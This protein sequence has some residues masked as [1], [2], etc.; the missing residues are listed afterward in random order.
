MN[1]VQHSRTVPV[2]PILRLTHLS[3]GYGKRTVLRDVTFEVGVGQ[4]W[5]FLGQNGGGKT[6][7][8]K[9]ILGLLPP[10]SGSLW[11]HPD[12]AKRDKTGFVP[13]RCDLNPSLPTTV[14]EF[15]LL[16]LVGV[17]VSRQEQQARLA[18]TLDKM[19]LTALAEHNYWSLSGGQ[20]Q[21]TLVARALVRRP[22]LLVL[23][24]P[25]NNLDLPTE[26]ALLQLLIALNQTEQQT[27][28]FVT[29]DL[30]LA[31]RYATHIALLHA[32]QALAGPRQQVLTPTN[33]AKLY[34]T[35]LPQL[36]SLVAAATEATPPTGD[37]Q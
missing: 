34:G 33:L 9:T 10:Q 19:G 4:V 8:M 26:D 30:S 21:R 12:L 36:S 24:E 35:T 28:L 27:L 15:V 31:A 7:L 11:L 5:F 1:S 6:T 3:L 32:G 2:Q 23:D 14:R 29:H 16:G 20:R 18:W 17:T 37:V 22:T 13:Q 25:T